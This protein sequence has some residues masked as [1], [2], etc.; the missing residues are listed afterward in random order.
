MR[1]HPLLP[2]LFIFFF[3][4]RRLFTSSEAEAMPQSQPKKW[5]PEYWEDFNVK[6]K[7][8]KL[9]AVRKTDRGTR[10][11]PVDSYTENFFD[12]YKLY[13]YL[14]LSC[15]RIVQ[16]GASHGKFMGRYKEQFGWD[17]IGYDYS[18][19]AISEMSKKGIVAKK[20]DLNSMSQDKKNLSYELEL[21][22]DVMEASHIFLFRVLQHL[23]P[24]PFK[25]LLCLLIDSAAPGSIFFIAGH[26]D[27]DAKPKKT[28]T[29]RTYNYKA[30][31]FARTDMQFL[32]MQNTSLDE[33]IL[34][35]RKIPRVSPG[36]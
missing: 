22:Q 11:V 24:E 27:K 7:T 18:K 33:E 36:A 28:L 16:L 23:D 12:Y 20:V 25:R 29:P 26:I 10:L 6:M 17:V 4:V 30:S 34:V 19:T 21:S 32:R 14:D 1:I 2:A 15:K 3:N 8:G 31:F 9:P 35:I 13:Q 5:S